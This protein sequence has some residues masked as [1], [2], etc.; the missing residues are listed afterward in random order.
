MD[1][2]ESQER[3]PAAPHTRLGP[4]ARTL[5]RAYARSG[6]SYPKRALLGG[7]L[8]G[9]LTGVF[10]TAGTALYI[11]MS[12]AEFARLAVASWIFIWTPE[13]VV[14][15]RLLSR[16]I[17][18]AC[19]WLR[20]ERDERQT[21]RAWEAAATLPLAR[22]RATLP[23]V[24]VVPGMVLWGVYAVGQLDLPTYSI[25]IFFAASVLVYL[26]WLAAHFLAIE[27]A[28]RPV[29]ED[30]GRSLPEKAEIA[31]LRVSLR[32][33]L[34]ASLVAVTL[35]TGV[36]VGGFAAG[37][38]EEI[39]A[40]GFA[41]L[42]SAV[43]AAL[44]SSWLIG[45]LSSSITRPIS[46]LRDAARRVGRGDLGVRVPLASTD[47]SG[48][49]ELAFNEMVAGLQQRERLR[50]A[51]GT[52]VDPDLTERV[53]EEGTDLAGDEVELSI[54][55]MDIRGFTSY[56]ETAEP[57]E[58]VARLNDLYGEV[59]P[60]ILRQG[61]HANKFIGDG[62]LAVF[63]APNRLDDHADRAVEAGLEITRIVR[64]RYEGDLRVGIGVNSGRVVAG[65]IGGGGRLDFTVIGD[66]VN[67]AARVESATRETDDDLLITEATRTRLS[68]GRPW[69]ERPAMP[70]K[71][72][73]ESI[74][75]FAPGSTT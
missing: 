3:I 11:D 69:D 19:A 72:K 38:T 10:G 51:F 62:L 53:L 56:S 49:L 60:V 59:V 5:Q 29:V 24:L 46:Q 7:L 75:L 2:G 14:S 4:L 6:A 63:G 1:T 70:L 9:Y 37:E 44:V 64:D 17:E 47:E 65:T 48:E 35:I 22:L 54:L 61:G 31:P 8:T 12:A 52:F 40:L 57:R 58:V 21:V 33:R 66:T 67:T 50:E 71:G 18:P 20:G 32:W 16:R 74:P 13:S 68:S 42:G 41:L 73:S 30:I 45:F 23:Y 34:L 55:F 39:A 26:Y 25:A 43:V 28:L 36:A 15:G 27:L